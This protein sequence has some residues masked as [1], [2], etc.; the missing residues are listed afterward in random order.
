LED[1]FDASVVVYVLPPPHATLAEALLD[2]SCV[3]AP[4]TP[5][6]LASCRTAATAAAAAA[7]ATGGTASPAGTA[8]QQSVA[9]APQVRMNGTRHRKA[10]PPERLCSA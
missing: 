2:A 6:G 7:A 3:L 8:S 9:A 10:A 5:G 4:V 1:T